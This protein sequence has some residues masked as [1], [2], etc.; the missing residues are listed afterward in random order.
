MLYEIDEDG[1]WPKGG[2]RHFAPQAVDLLLVVALSS[3]P[4]SFLCNLEQ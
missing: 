4:R 1:P 3:T 2:E